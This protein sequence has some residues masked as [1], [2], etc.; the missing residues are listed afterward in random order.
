MHGQAFLSVALENPSCGFDGHG[1]G[2]CSIPLQGM[3]VSASSPDVTSQDLIVVA[4]D[5]GSMIGEG[6]QITRG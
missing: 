6:Y 2:P 5:S 3:F 4:T 1:G